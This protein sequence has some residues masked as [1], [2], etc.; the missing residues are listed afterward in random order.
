M[1]S[2]SMTQ[3]QAP[4]PNLA[5]QLFGPRAP[6]TH[7]PRFI[8]E[9]DPLPA[10]VIS[11]EIISSTLGNS[12]SRYPT[13]PKGF[14]VNNET[15]AVVA[16]V[17]IQPR[18][19]IA[20]FIWDLTRILLFVVALYVAYPFLSSLNEQIRDGVIKPY[21]TITSSSLTTSQSVSKI[22]PP[23]E[24]ITPTALSPC[25]E[26]NTVLSSSSVEVKASIEG[27]PSSLA[28]TSG[29]E[30]TS[31]SS[32]EPDSTE[33]ELASKEVQNSTA[34][35]LTSKSEPDEESAP[36]PTKSSTAFSSL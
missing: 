15:P 24:S 2:A 7:P 31:L 26:E 5:D 1:A 28:T 12:V 17:P 16:S 8:R 34:D 23:Y 10:W 35:I 36:S 9:D 21:S 29:S 19:A 22:I 13:G 14:R 25:K 33:V 20:K 18:R 6:D 27:K 3:P 30:T 11:P 32:F 4:I